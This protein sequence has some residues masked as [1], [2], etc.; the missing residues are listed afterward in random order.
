MMPKTIS[1]IDDLTPDSRNANRGT[2]RGAVQVESSLSKYGAGRSI[3]ADAE[4]RI[5]AGN[6]TLQAA[7]DLQI[8]VRVV[9]TDGRELVVVQRTDLDLLSD[10]HRA[11]ML[12]YA[13]NRA[14]EVGLEWN[15]EEIA[16]DLA[17]GVELGE[18]F[19][20]WELEGIVGDIVD[21][22][23]PDDSGAQVDIPEQWMILIECDNETRQAELLY[24]F[25]EEGLQCHALIS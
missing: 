14:S 6:K 19:L 2:E 8:P 23:T 25:A 17:E 1:S 22:D 12:A 18:L 7:A 24:R 9:Q 13:D 16:I 21:A 4:G 5:I 11:R 10:D 15:A 3:L 20:D